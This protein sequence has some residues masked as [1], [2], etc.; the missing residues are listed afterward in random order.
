MKSHAPRKK[1]HRIVNRYKDC[2][3][4]LRG[5]RP[6][7]FF[8]R[9]RLAPAS[10]PLV[11]PACRRLRSSS[12]L[13]ST[14]CCGLPASAPPR[15]PASAPPRVAGM[16]LPLSLHPR[17]AAG[18]EGSEKKTP[19]PVSRGNRNLMPLATPEDANSTLAFNLW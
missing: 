3:L 13:R 11:P 16:L 2:W 4:P 8:W 6:S 1:G 15:A 5:Y 14:S 7:R 17:V 12:C 18:Y 9:R 19:S 10:V